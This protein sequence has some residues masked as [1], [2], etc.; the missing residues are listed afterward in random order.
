MGA[1][2]LVT[3]EYGLTGFPGSNRDEWWDY[4]VD[5]PDLEPGNLIRRNPCLQAGDFPEVMRR[6]SCMARAN[7]VVLIVGLIDLKHCWPDSYPGCE[8]SRDGSLLFN[9]ALGFDADGAYIAKYHKS[10]LWGE[11]AVDAGRDCVLPEFHSTELDTSFGIFVCADLINAWPA[12]DLV[13]KGIHHFVMPLSWSNEMLQ[14]Q[15]LPWIQA[16]SKLMNVTVAAA[17]ARSPFSQS[18]SGIF[19]AGVPLAVAYDLLAKTQDDLV[20]AS[21]PEYSAPRSLPVTC[22]TPVPH[23]AALKPHGSPWLT[24][25]LNMSV[26]HHH[27]SVCS[28]YQPGF[29]D[30]PTCCDVTY[31]SQAPGKGYAVVLLSGVDVA[32]GIEPWAGEACAV[33]P[34]PDGAAD[35]LSYPK[36]VLLHHKPSWFG[37][38]SHVELHVKFSAPQLVFPQVLAG[39][40]LLSPSDWQL[41]STG[42][43]SYRLALS[44]DTAQQLV[45][46]QLYG[47]QYMKDPDASQKCPCVPPSLWL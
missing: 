2:L 7:R 42:R 27:V 24:Y 46:L 25:Q 14:M 15:P 26:G 22:P 21:V 45:S 11:H 41:E 3:P 16:W 13:G 20:V 35:C 29:A 5:I 23:T 9:T 18:G 40:G 31:T 36:E 47:R 6:L 8:L 43:A 32:P 44:G 33:V 28:N 10:N 34:C 1:Q 4:A 12:L 19:S 38:F 30:G 17:N 39:D 37:E